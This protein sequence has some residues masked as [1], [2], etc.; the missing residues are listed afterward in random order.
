MKIFQRSRN[1]RD[2]R[3]VKEIS[4]PGFS[5]LL[6]PLPLDFERQSLPPHP[7]VLDVR[8]SLPPHLEVLEHTPRYLLKPL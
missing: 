1:E 8:Q 4:T 5:A 6:R 2:L 7:E 3:L